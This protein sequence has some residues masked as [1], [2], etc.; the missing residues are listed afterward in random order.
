MA[1][2]THTSDGP[3]KCLVLQLLLKKKPNNHTFCPNG[4]ASSQILGKVEEKR[5]KSRLRTLPATISNQGVAS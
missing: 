4:L 2:S 1:V 3:E 5:D